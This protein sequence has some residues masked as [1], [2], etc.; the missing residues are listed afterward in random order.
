[1]MND[2]VS[3]APDRIIND[4]NTQANDARLTGLSRRG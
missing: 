4:G 3:S 1:M 2:P